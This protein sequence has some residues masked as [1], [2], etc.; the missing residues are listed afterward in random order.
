MG[1]GWLGLPL[2]NSLM[3][4]DYK[5]YG[6]TTSKHKL[7]KLQK[8]GIVPYLISISENSIDGSFA[9][10]LGKVDVLVI[11]IPPKLRGSSQ[12]S[13]V[14]KM[15]LVLDTLVQSKVRKLLFVSS[16]SVYGDVKGVVTEATIP[17][18]ATL[19]GKQLLA[20][21][22]LFNDSPCFETTI[23]RFGGLVGNDRH[24]ITRLS[25][26]KG[27]KNGNYPINLIHLDDCVSIMHEVIN[28][29]WWGELFNAVFPFHPSKKD[30]YEQESRKRGMALPNYG[31]DSPYQGKKI[32]SSK[33]I[34]VKKYVFKTSI[35]G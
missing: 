35:L 24:P 26:R 9:E 11:N 1:C 10:F 8:A 6:T 25:G 27:L 33:L 7:Q 12:E 13:Y 16:T 5:I 22:R 34:H 21:E 14:K 2:A 30:Y 28:N 15:Q 17:H 4:D 23:I 20:S 18:P 19:S 31:V 32:D 3:K 29:N